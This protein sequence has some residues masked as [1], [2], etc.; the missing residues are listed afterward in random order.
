MK[1]LLCFIFCIFYFVGKTESQNLVPNY[2]FE[3]YDTCPTGG[4]QIYYATPWFQPCIYYYNNTREASSSEYFNSCSSNFA[5]IPSNNFGYQYAKTG[6]GYAGIHLHPDTANIR[7]YIEVPLLDTLIANKNYCV[8]FY[9]SLSD[10]S[11]QAVSNFGA[12][13]SRD[14]LLD[15]TYYHAI[16]Y[17]TPQVEN[18][19]TNMLNNKTNW[20]LISG[21]FIAT[22]GERF[23]TLGNF[24]NNANTNFQIIMPSLYYAVAYYY[25]DD[26][27]VIYCDPS[28]IEEITNN[29]NFKLYPNPNDGTMQLTYTLPENE[30]AILTITNILGETLTTYKLENHST[31][32]NIKETKLENGIYFYQIYNNNKQVYSGKIIINK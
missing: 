24:H 1:A 28:G 20:T 4:N 9:V 29:N 23:L 21:S 22:G 27:S 16:D 26:I 15:S 18:P 8:Q 12:Y 14:S 19:L 17:V 10:T 6:N 5:T 31:S 3:V 13:F 11:N 7:E 2:S 25:I 32:L 30:N